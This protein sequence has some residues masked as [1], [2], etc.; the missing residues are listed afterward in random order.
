MGETSA[1]GW[2]DASWNPWHGCIKIS[3]GCKFCY[4]YRDKTRYGQDPTKV[5]R[6]KTTFRDPLKWKEPKLVFTCSW[7]D[8]FIEEAD[9]WRDEAW[10]VIRQT[11]HTYQILTKRPERIAGHLP[12]DWGEGWN[13]VW[14]GISGEAQAEFDERWEILRFVPSQ[15]RFISLEPLLSHIDLQPEFFER[16]DEFV[17]PDWV[18]VGGESGPQARPFDLVWARD[19]IERCGSAHIPCFIKQ[20]GSNP[21]DSDLTFSGRNESLRL[22]DSHGANWDEW[23]E[24]LRVREFPINRAS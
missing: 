24:D 7:S 6:S 15:T 14:L 11:P 21:F 16:C 5:V 10:A 12:K 3:A 13:N 17:W 8:F 4:M 19:I 20:L 23:P 1:I 22:K 18:I 2:T 9:E